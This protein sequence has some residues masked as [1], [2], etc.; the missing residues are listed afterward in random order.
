MWGGAGGEWKKVGRFEKFERFLGGEIYRILGGFGMENEEQI[1]QN[2]SYVW[3]VHLNGQKCH[4]L[5][6]N[7]LQ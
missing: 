4:S 2:E 7:S 6:C 3:P 1:A 5:E